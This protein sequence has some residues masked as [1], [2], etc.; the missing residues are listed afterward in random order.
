MVLTINDEDHDDWVLMLLGMRQLGMSDQECDDVLEMLVQRIPLHI[1]RMRKPVV[2]V[3]QHDYALVR[4][5]PFMPYFESVIMKR[6]YNGFFGWRDGVVPTIGRK[7]LAPGTFVV[8]DDDG[9]MIEYA[10]PMVV[11]RAVM[12][13]HPDVYG[14]WETLKAIA[15]DFA[16]R[17]DAV[18]VG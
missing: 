18:V 8:F 10:E 11:S 5:C 7:V 4:V 2:A 9:R 17:M 3:N 15:D 13:D 12:E 14:H 6:A 1:L 16:E